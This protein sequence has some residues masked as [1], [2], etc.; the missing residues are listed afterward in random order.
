MSHLRIVLGAMLAVLPLGGCYAYAEPPA[1]ETVAYAPVLYEGYVVYYDR[2]GTPYIY[3]N[4]TLAYL[5]P[6]AAQYDALVT[7][8]REHAVAYR[9]WEQRQEPARRERA[10][11]ERP[12]RERN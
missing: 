7:N 8:Y 12:R 1:Y 4:G 9:E 3:D 5:P 2:G 6:T 11:R 10:G